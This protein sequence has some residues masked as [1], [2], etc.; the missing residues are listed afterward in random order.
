MYM[1]RSKKKETERETERK[2]DIQTDKMRRNIPGEE[3]T[4]TLILSTKEKETGTE[5]VKQTVRQTDKPT[6][7]QT[8]KLT[9]I[10]KPFEICNACF[11]RYQRLQREGG[12]SAAIFLRWWRRLRIM[13]RCSEMIT[14]H[15]RL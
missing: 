4:H 8:D 11:V 13:S 2:T 5:R 14:V 3:K 9:D 1:D 15:E 6:D 10:E 12:G 7:R